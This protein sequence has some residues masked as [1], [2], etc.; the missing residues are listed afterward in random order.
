MELEVIP[1]ADDRVKV[2]PKEA[3]GHQNLSE[4]QHILKQ[5]I[6]EGRINI[7][8]DFASISYL[9]SAGLGALIG[10]NALLKSKQGSLTITGITPAL[11]NIFLAFRLDAILGVDLG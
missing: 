7:E 10:L 11:K 5:W 3:L 8:L 2:A 6:D 9:D 1:I 4:F